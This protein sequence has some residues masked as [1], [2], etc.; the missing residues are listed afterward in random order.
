MYSFGRNQH[1]QLGHSKLETFDQPTKIEELND[2]NIIQAACGRNHSLFLTDTGIVYACGDNT[3]GQLGIGK[4]SQKI[5]TK[6]T[7][8][9]YNGAPIVKVDCGAVFSVIL[10]INGN[11]YTF[12]SPEHGQL[13]ENSALSYSTIKTI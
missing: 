9:D 12:G 8:I 6:P 2:V 3:N 13:G 5:V 4:V 10:D 7:R 11:L 1:G